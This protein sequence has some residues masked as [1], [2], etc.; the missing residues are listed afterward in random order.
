MMAEFPTEQLV[1][2][3]RGIDPCAGAECIESLQA[4]ALAAGEAG[5]DRV[6]GL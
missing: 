6:A 1:S 4:P 2:F 5:K 3:V